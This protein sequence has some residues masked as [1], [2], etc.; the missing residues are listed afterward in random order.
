MRIDRTD[1]TQAT[2]AEFYWTRKVGAGHFS[3]QVRFNAEGTSINPSEALED[4]LRRFVCHLIVDEV[5]EKGLG[6]M[7][8]SL[9]NM[10][11]FYILPD[12][13]IRMLPA[14]RQTAAVVG[15][16]GVRP[17]FQFDSDEE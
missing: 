4:A 9:K 17:A 7:C 15:S 3:H 11:D 16:Q 6:E 12:Q 1:P 14:A 10:Y 13:P 2:D 5:P 8:D